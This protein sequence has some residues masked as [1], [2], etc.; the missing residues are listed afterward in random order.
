LL[1]GTPNAYSAIFGPNGQ[2]IGEPVADVEGITYAEIDLDACIAPKQFHDIVGHYNRADIF[3]LRV[4]RT[5]QS[6]LQP[7]ECRDEWPSG[8]AT[9]PA[10]PLPDAA[11]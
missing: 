7:V 5:P 10:E 6:L 2:I 8:V 11:E 9:F 3:R 1:T 4:D